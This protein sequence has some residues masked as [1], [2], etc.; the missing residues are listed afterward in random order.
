MFVKRS[1]RDQLACL[2]DFV[3]ND[4]ACSCFPATSTQLF[5]QIFSSPI[6]CNC[7]EIVSTA[8]KLCNF[9]RNVHQQISS[10]TFCSGNFIFTQKWKCGF[11]NKLCKC[12]EPLSTL[13]TKLLYHGIST[14][15]AAT[16][17]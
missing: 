17:L 4:A 2:V 1:P 14:C 13:S 3:G 9:W 6:L 5:S 16:I 10:H 12:T 8:N 11:R 7:L 15:H